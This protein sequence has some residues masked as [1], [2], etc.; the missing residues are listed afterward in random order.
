MASRT[1]SRTPGGA[2][3]GGARTGTAKTTRSPA[4]AR[5][6]KPAARTPAKRSPAKRPPVGPSAG[7]RAGKVLAGGWG[8]LAKGAGSIVRTLGRTKELDPA[9]RRDGVGF[10]LI[11]LGVVLGAA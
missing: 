11:A 2:K 1:P 4:A 5:T 7:K 3:G 10:A 8:L 6:R 9:H